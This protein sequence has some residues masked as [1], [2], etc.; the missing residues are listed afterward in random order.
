[1]S[2]LLTQMMCCPIYE[3]V[4]LL[5]VTILAQHNVPFIEGGVPIFS[6][7]LV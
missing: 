1:M 4:Q 3:C 5:Q 7:V 6:E 2:T